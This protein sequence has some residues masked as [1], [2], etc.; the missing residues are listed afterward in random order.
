[1]NSNAM[2]AAAALE[3]IIYLP[4]QSMRTARSARAIFHQ[5]ASQHAIHVNIYVYLPP[6]NYAYSL[7]HTEKCDVCECV[8]LALDAHCVIS[9]Q[10]V[11]GLYTSRTSNYVHTHE[12]T[13]HE[14]II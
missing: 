12:D 2:E 3:I 1:M 14:N 6:H 4:S 5:N 7:A 11:A 8:R 13:T 9:T 10:N